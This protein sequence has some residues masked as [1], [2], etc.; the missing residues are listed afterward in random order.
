MAVFSEEF[1][2]LLLFL[3]CMNFS[4]FIQAIEGLI[5]AIYSKKRHPN[6]LSG[7]FG[8]FIINTVGLLRTSGWFWFHCNVVE[9]FL[10]FSLFTLVLVGTNP[11]KR[12]VSFGLGTIFTIFVLFLCSDKEKAFI[13]DV[14]RFVLAFLAVQG[15]LP[16]YFLQEKVPRAAALTTFRFWTGNFA[17]IYFGYMEGGWLSPFTSSTL[18]FFFNNTGLLLVYLLNGQKAQKTK[19]RDSKKDN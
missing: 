15:N 2:W 14:T 8:N 7:I 10:A 1:L 17:W 4:G 6:T 5:V 9:Y 12:G 16:F 11:L 19:T 13:G 18:I 3:D